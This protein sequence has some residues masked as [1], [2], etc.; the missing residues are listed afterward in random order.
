MDSL[1]P[2][3]KVSATDRTPRGPRQIFGANTGEERPRTAHAMKLAPAAMGRA[4]SIT[5]LFYRPPTNADK[6]QAR[7]GFVFIGVIGG[8]LNRFL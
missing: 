5:V 7:A 8:Y 2:S 6:K 3:S 1:G 4:V